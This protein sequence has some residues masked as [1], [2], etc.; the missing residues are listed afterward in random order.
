MTPLQEMFTKPQFYMSVSSK[1]GLHTRSYSYPMAGV[2]SHTFE[3]DL[4]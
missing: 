3:K 4:S 1:P 2:T